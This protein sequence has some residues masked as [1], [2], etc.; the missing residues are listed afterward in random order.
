MDTRRL[1]FPPVLPALLTLLLGLSATVALFAWTRGQ[2]QAVEQ[3][4]FERRA[5]YRV[6]TVRQGLENMIQA[7]DVLNRAF[8]TFG[9]LSSRQF[10]SFVEPLAGKPPYV[11]AM[12]FLRMV[13]QAERSAYEAQMQ[14]VYPGFAVR[15]LV[16]GKLVTAPVRDRYVVIEYLKPDEP[17]VLG[18]GYDVL[19]PHHLDTALERAAETGKA[20]AAPLFH[21]GPQSLPR[22]VI[23]KAVYR[24][25]APLATLEERRAAV[26]GY[27][28]GGM[29]SAKLIERILDASGMLRTPGMEI[30]VYAGAGSADAL[31]YHATWQAPRKSK[32]GWWRWSADAPQRQLSQSFELAGL[33]WRVDVRGGVDPAAEPQ[34]GSWLVALFGMSISLMAA[35]YLKAL[36]SQTQRIHKLVAERT[37][38]L[39]TANARLN[40]DILAR[41]RMEGALRRTEYS[42]K[43][44]QRIAHV[45]SWETDIASGTHRWSDECFRIFGL[46]PEPD[47]I[48]AMELLPPA[49][50][51]I[52]RNYLADVLSGGSEGQECSI[53]RPDGSV[54]CVMLHA[55]LASDAGIGAHTVIGSVLDITEFKRVETELRKSRASL[56]ELGGHQ[57]RI[58]ENERKRIAREIHDELGG[59]LT[60]IR[61]YVS[62]ARSR[63]GEGS[64]VAPLLAEAM[65]QADI[66]IDTVRRV[67]A[68]LRPSVLDQLGVWAAIEWQAG[69]LEAQT[70]VQCHCVI[71][72]DLPVV[73]PDS[74]VMLFRIVQ[75]ALT[76]VARHA[77]ATSVEIRAGWDGDVLLLE[78]ED[79]GIGI[80]LNGLCERPSWGLRGMHERAHHL[81]G[82]LA[83][84]IAAN[85]G[86][87]VSLRFPPPMKL[88]EVVL[89]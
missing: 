36:G 18:P 63:A 69:Q 43:N 82:S 39:Y 59:L 56:R 71:E 25:G 1:S 15:D 61:A 65:A 49:T 33:A 5:S 77:R 23:V 46:A 62:V 17:T 26:Q 22:V 19:S 44:A 13:H 20:S 6:M 48:L 11:C 2:E 60:G 35:F 31:A 87:L 29:A 66:A 68:D 41:Q 8:I 86:T 14:A 37:A 32:A 70:G 10:E 74:G 7:V 73:G 79:N 27:T 80:A 42:L 16:N 81:G 64:A 21:F 84:T 40:A 51:D 3:M 75:E 67:I 54:R 76:N 55:A 34:P 50:R 89:Q 47:G 53:V 85:G 12:S 9:P 88:S 28:A 24:P 58:K 78:I 4:I 57:E 45:G 83:L 30:S 38:A 72:P 52:W